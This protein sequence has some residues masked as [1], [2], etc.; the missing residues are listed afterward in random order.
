MYFGLI[1]SCS[2]RRPLIPRAPVGTVGIALAVE[3]APMHSGRATA[4]PCTLRGAWR[5]A[6]AGQRRRAH[7]GG[8]SPPGDMPPPAA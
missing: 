6:S 4:A 7:V 5:A 2:A 3:A 8:G 1:A